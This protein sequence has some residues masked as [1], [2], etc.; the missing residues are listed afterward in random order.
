[1]LRSVLPLIP[2]DM[3]LAMPCRRRYDELFSGFDN[4]KTETV[5]S[6]PRGHHYIKMPAEDSCIAIFSGRPIK[7]RMVLEIDFEVFKP[8]NIRPLPLDLS[9]SLRPESFKM[10]KR[11]SLLKQP[12]AVIS[13]HGASSPIRKDCPIPLVER[14]CDDLQH[15]GLLPVVINFGNERR[16]PERLL[17]TAGWPEA[18][19]AL[20]ALLAHAQA[21]IGIDSGP[22][23]MAL[24]IAKLP[25]VFLHNQID[26]LRCFYDSGMDQIRSVIDV[27]KEPSNRDIR[28]AIK[29]LL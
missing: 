13:G 22:M 11:I 1:M 4:V 8:A 3:E 15:H 7:A 16:Y 14:I 23:H 2:Y 9:T 5:D 26:F 20:W 19:S 18:E 17:T 24:T 6:M 28:T 29:T 21:F 10:L 12:Y 27:K 25:C